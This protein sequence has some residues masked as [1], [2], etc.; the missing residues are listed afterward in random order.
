MFR[1]SDLVVRCSCWIDVAFV[2]DFDVFHAR[3]GWSFAR[4][5]VF[6]GTLLNYQ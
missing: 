2:S 1:P 5:R 3:S 4:N 6:D